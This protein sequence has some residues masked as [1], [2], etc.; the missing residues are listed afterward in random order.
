MRMPTVIAAKL[1]ITAE[2]VGGLAL[3]GVAAIGEHY[4]LLVGMIVSACLVLAG[5]T[6]FFIRKWMAERENFEK[7][8]IGSHKELE[9]TVGK[10]VIVVDDLKHDIGE[11]TRSRRR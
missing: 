1:L 2:A 10:L 4:D 7:L 5:S 8:D 6:L 11:L 3:A 9:I